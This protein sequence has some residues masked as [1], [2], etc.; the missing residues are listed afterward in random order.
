MPITQSAK[1]ALR[2][3]YKKKMFNLRAKES[4]SKTV[5]RVKKLLTEKKNKEAKALISS[6]QK[7]LDK[8]AK[9]GLIKK[10]AAARKKSRMSS[11]IKKAS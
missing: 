3:S 10:G 1:K 5:K 6:V 4:I 7:V 9:T 11:M 2:A 8:A